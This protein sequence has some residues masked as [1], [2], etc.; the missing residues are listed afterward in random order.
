MGA[1]NPQFFSLL[2]THFTVNGGKDFL[3]GCFHAFGT[4]DRHIGDFLRRI[5]EDTTDNVGRSF[6]EDIGENAVELQIGNGQT[7]LRTVLFA[8][9][10]VCEFYVVA[11]KVTKLTDVGGR[12][13]A[14]GNKVV[15]ENVGNPLSILFVGFLAANRFDILGVCQNDFAVRFKDVVNWN[16]VLSRAFHTDITAV[17]LQKPR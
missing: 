11:Y 8:C 17:V 10:I 7:I 2:G 5:G 3:I 16:L 9:G 6:T 13:K 4:K 15:L 1:D 14:A 12:N